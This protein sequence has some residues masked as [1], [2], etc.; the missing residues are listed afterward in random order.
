VAEKKDGGRRWDVVL[1]A[2]PEKLRTPAR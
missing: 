1:V 2:L